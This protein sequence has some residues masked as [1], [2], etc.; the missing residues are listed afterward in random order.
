MTWSRYAADEQHHAADLAE[1]FVNA[2]GASTR[3]RA[4]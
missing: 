4:E 1:R 3:K 2:G